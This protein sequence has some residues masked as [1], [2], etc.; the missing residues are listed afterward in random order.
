MIGDIARDYLD[1]QIRTSD[2]VERLSREALV[3]D[4]E[5]FVMFI[6]RRRTRVLAYAS[7][8]RAVLHELGSRRLA[9]MRDLL[10]GTL[11]PRAQGQ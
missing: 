3:A 9:G 10:L 1:N 4:P 6:E 5:A 2:A 11:E 7:G 8:R